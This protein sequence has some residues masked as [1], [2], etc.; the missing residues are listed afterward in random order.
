MWKQLSVLD[1]LSIAIPNQET[2]GAKFTKPCRK[3]GEEKVLEAFPLFSTSEAGRKNTCKQCS[4]D[5][6][7]VRTRLRKMHPAPP[8]G[9]CPVCELH[10]DSWV[11]D[12]NHMAETFRGYIC[13]SCNLGFGKFN[14]DPNVL[15]RALF[16]LLNSTQPNATTKASNRC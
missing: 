7:V 8:P 11:L 15:E 1:V 2:T 13:N 9:V 5:L 14:D 16:Y 10:T 3:C 12:H 4:K 6:S